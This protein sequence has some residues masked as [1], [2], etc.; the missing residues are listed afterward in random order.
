MSREL[1]VQSLWEMDIGKINS[2][3]VVKSQISTL[4]KI[5]Y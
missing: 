3:K 2:I 5:D 1:M 4:K